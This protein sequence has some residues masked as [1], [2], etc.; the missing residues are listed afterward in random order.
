MPRANFASTL[1]QFLDLSFG[2]HHFPDIYHSV[3]PMAV[4]LGVWGSWFCR[5][6]GSAARAAALQREA[7]RNAD[8]F[9]LGRLV[10]AEF[11]VQLTVWRFF[12]GFQAAEAE[13]SQRVKVCIDNSPMGAQ[14]GR[15]CGSC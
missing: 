11:H 6:L 10:F 5:R 13:I 12:G 8:R 9:L 2:I 14:W 4:V 3:S 15:F 1:D 7:H